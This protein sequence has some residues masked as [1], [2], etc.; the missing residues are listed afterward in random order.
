MS[1]ITNITITA[2]HVGKS[3]SMNC[4][5]MSITQEFA[6]TW[7]EEQ[8]Y[9]KMDPISTFS[10]TKRTLSVDFVLLARTLSEAQNM[11]NDVGQLIRFQYPKYVGQKGGGAALKSPPFFKIKVLRG[12]L[13]SSLQGYITSITI[14]PG[15]NEDV[16][17]LV[18]TSG[19]FFE[20]KYVINFAMTVLHSSVVGYVNAKE[21]GGSGFV[22][23]PTA[24]AARANRAVPPA[25][26]PRGEIASQ[27][28][29]RSDRGHDRDRVRF[30][31]PIAA[32]ELV[33]QGADPDSSP[34]DAI[35]SQTSGMEF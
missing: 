3:I 16:V 34:I 15:S 22:F 29:H 21:P 17:P 33:S 32:K 9:G 13:Y 5:D 20:R 30:S 25:I 31:Q 14:N 10:H 19:N 26:V 24:A 8:T 23:A 35:K 1:T 18:D 27:A 28:A 7:A 4:A 2:M 6:P 11:Q 12:K